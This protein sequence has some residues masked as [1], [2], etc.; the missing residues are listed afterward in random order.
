MKR[1]YLLTVVCVAALLVTACGASSEELEGAATAAVA[2][3]QETVEAKPTATSPPTATPYPTYTPAPSSTP[4]PTYTP[5]STFTPV[6]TVAPATANIANLYCNFDFC[7]R[8][9]E[10][11][12]VSIAVYAEDYIDEVF[13][14][15]NTREEGGYS[16]LTDDVLVFL[17][18]YVEVFDSPADGVTRAL[19]DPDYS[20]VGKVEETTVNSL[21]VAYAPYT[22]DSSRYPHRVFAIWRCGSRL[23]SYSIRS[24][25][26]VDLIPFLEGA[27]ADFVC[28]EGAG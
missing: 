20:D 28:A 18:W 12:T 26:D 17:N 6:P 25:V 13:D 7:I 9:P 27:L 21:E 22:M 3:Y 1:P 16:W 5:A 19:D 24:Q 2:A 10:D 8:H 4:L 11:P 23:F 15:L 14:E